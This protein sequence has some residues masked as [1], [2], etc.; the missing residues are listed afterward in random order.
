V[1]D[2][3]TYNSCS[4]CGQLYNATLYVTNSLLTENVRRVLLTKEDIENIKTF[5]PYFTTTMSN[6]PTPEVFNILSYNL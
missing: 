1:T 6:I 2:L 5:G 4:D 3:T